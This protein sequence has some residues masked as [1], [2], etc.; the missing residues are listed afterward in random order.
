MCRHG[1]VL[2]HSTDSEDFPFAI[3]LK[4]CLLWVPTQE[5]C[6]LRYGFTYGKV[7]D[8]IITVHMPYSVLLQS[9]AYG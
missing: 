3:L 7:T 4:Y 9:L 5:Y 1:P 2:V 6:Q 8:A